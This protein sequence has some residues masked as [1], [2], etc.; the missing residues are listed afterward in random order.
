MAIEKLK[1]MNL[2]FMKDEENSILSFLQDFGGLEI[3]N[4]FS[5]DKKKELFLKNKKK[6]SFTQEKDLDTEKKLVSQNLFDMSRLKKAIEILEFYK[7]KENF[8]TKL[9]SKIFINKNS[10]DKFNDDYKK[11]LLF[12]S[13]EI[14]FLT[15]DLDSYKNK[16]AELND[17]IDAISVWTSITHNLSSTFGTNYTRVLAFEIEEKKYLNFL[18]NVNQKFNK[19]ED[20][21]FEFFEIN[22]SNNK[23]FIAVII[24]YELSSTF[25]DI[26]SRF[27]ILENWGKIDKTPHDLLMYLEKYK[28]AL[29]KKIENLTKSIKKRT[30]FLEDMKILYDEILNEH[31]RNSEKFN[32]YYGENIGIISAWIKEK[33]IEKFSDKLEKSFSSSFLNI[34]NIEKIVD[35]P[36]IL[37][38]NK[39]VSPF[40]I[41]TDLYGKPGYFGIDPTP[42]FAGFFWIFFGVC[43]GDAGYGLFMIFISLFF[44][45]IKK[46]KAMSS[47]INLLFFMGIS[48]FLAGMFTGTFFGNIIKFLP[49]KLDFVVKI[50]NKL[51]LINPMDQKGSLIFLGVSLCFGYIQLCFGMILKI[52]LF[53]RDKDYKNLFLDGF[54]SLFMEISLLP[55]TLHYVLGFLFPKFIISI[56]LFLFFMSMILIGIKEWIKNEGIMVKIF[57][58]LYG[59]YS[60]ITGNFLS[61]VLSY[62]RLFALGLSGGLLGLA[63]NEI[64]SI[65]LNIPIVGIFFMIIIFIFGHLF[66]L[67]VSGLGAFV[68][69]CRLQYLEFFT[70]FFESN[71]RGV[72]Y[73]QRENFFTY[74][75]D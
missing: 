52:Y 60:A 3:S 20:R 30:V 34:E 24:Y 68:H 18:E 32:I 46:L 19:E 25:K 6:E 45:Y 61:D 10:L 48:T 59:N 42:H 56:F 11:T 57:W 8:F 58:C 72:K 43:L 4:I 74:L 49:E 28:K 14:N 70:K 22:K 5:D 53:F 73:F 41:I 33:D 64:S 37:K 75:K 13:D 29:L 47:I 65:F 50:F 38:N 35:I 1:K 39:L 12:V 26:I 67:A 27:G 54:S 31:I 23:I 17:N 21:L 51:T 2:F 9:N 15:K 69:S 44:K 63:V 7:E 16:I 36:V 40:E 71:G 66:N 55:I 62:A